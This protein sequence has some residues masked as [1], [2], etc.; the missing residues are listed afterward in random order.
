MSDMAQPGAGSPQQG[1]LSKPNAITNN[2][3]ALNP[4][5]VGLM[6]QTGTINKNMTIKDWIETVLK[7]PITAPVTELAGA[8]MKHGKNRTMI[9][10]AQSMAQQAPRPGMGAGMRSSPQPAPQQGGG[11]QGLMSAL[12]Q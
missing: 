3:S 7:V 8:L 12:K 2:M 11:L 1:L 9:G 4:A 10:K 6:A 5:D